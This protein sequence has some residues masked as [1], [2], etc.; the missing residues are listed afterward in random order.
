MGIKAVTIDGSAAKAKLIKSLGGETCV[1]FTQEK[2][3][4]GWVA[5]A[6]NGGGLE[7]LLGIQL[8]LFSRLNLLNSGKH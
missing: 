5:K 3:L 7:V 4:V 2:D 6:T 1:N 8:T